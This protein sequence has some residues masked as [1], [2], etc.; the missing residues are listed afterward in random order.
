M[1]L[2]EKNLS[3]ILEEVAGHCPHPT[4]SNEDG[5][6]ASS[7]LSCVNSIWSIGSACFIAGGGRLRLYTPTQEFQNCIKTLRNGHEAHHLTEKNLGEIKFTLKCKVRAMDYS[8]KIKALEQ[9]SSYFG[10]WQNEVAERCC[11]LDVFS[12]R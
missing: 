11:K 12:G 2:E 8:S 7:K 1:C 9:R 3:A 5:P 6:A 10:E 4:H